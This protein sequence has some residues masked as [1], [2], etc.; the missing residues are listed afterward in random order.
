VLEFEEMLHGIAAPTIEL[1]GD[2]KTLIFTAS[3]AQ[4]ER[5]TE[6]I[7]RHKPKSARWV[8]GGTPKEERRA[9][10]PAYAEGEFQYLV[11][12]GV[13][14][15]GFDEPGI[16]VVVMA[17]PTKSRSLYAQ[18]VG[19]GTRTLPGVIDHIDESEHRKEAI[20]ES[21]KPSLEVIDFVGNAG[22]HKLI[23]S[24]D[25]L[26]G[27]F[28]DA[29]VERAKSNTKRKSVD[30]GLPVDVI[31]ELQIAEWQIEKEE[32]EAAEA[33]RRKHLKL[34]AKYSTAKINPFDIYGIEPWR[35]RAWHKG[36]QPTDK[37][38]AFLEHSGID[39]SG[40]S[41]T[42]AQQ[43][44]KRLI[45]NREQGKCSYKQAKLLQR[46]GY[47]PDVSF[48]QASEIISELAA[49]GWKRTA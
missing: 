45:E 25:I 8:H 2:R 32:R 26:G 23:T 36:R 42:H 21:G 27:R 39:I 48:E 33:A 41:F 43:L 30:N 18:M 9:L 20:A 19:R 46:Y 6:I 35:E 29:V 31:D 17:R 13:T 7:N 12:V 10:F 40:L 15:E 1:T 49:N 14:T 3:L 24:A 37:Q 5:I 47:D 44:I 11:N 34:R 38:I 22:R 4:A 16:E 28:D